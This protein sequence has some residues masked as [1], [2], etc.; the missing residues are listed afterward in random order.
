M[1][2]GKDAFATLIIITTMGYAGITSWLNA[3]RASAPYWFVW[4]LIIVQ[5]ILYFYIFT[6]SY[7]R[8]KICG[9]NKN[10]GFIIFLALAILG[11]VNDWEIIVIPLTVIIMLIVSSKAKNISDKS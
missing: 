10:F 9:L 7:I 11:R 1:K 2:I 4:I 3:I 5:L 8:A 6:A